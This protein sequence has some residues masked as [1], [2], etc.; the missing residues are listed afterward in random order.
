VLNFVQMKIHVC[1]ALHA[2][3]L[4]LN[5]VTE[6]DAVSKSK[7]ANSIDQNLKEANAYY[8]KGNLDR[9]LELYMKCLKLDPNQ[10]DCL[11]N[12]GSVLLDAGKVDDA[13]IHYRRAL[14]VT[15][16]NHAGALYNLALM[17]QD[18]VKEGDLT[19]SRNLYLR[20]VEIET[21]NE[22]AW[23]NLGAVQHQLGDLKL[24]IKSY[25]K[26]IELY[27]DKNS[28][29]ENNLIMSTLHENVGRVTLRLSERITD[30]TANRE[31][32]TA[33]ALEF[34]QAAVAFNP[35][36]EVLS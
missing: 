9:A 26:A 21:K 30:S 16:G 8:G 7:D 29:G 17:L 28:E 20:L 6:A 15:A 5:L 4:F 25:M 22:E 3:I 19:E 24:A 36:N 33:K 23:A 18:G 35:S 13:K 27:S 12:L 34:L 11:C 1:F 32:V 10:P 2:L 14:K 31:A